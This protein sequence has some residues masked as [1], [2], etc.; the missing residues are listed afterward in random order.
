[1][2]LQVGSGEEGREDEDEESG[3]E[4][5]NLDQYL[6]QGAFSFF[7]IGGIDSQRILTC[8]NLSYT[9]IPPL[10]LPPPPP[11]HPP[12]PPGEEEEEEEDEEDERGGEG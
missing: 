9:C 5:G 4:G 8:T 1:M 6:A 10:P 11:R 12:P 3:E 2:A 7:F